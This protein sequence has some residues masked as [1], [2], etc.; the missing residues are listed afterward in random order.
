MAETARVLFI[1]SSAT[2]LPVCIQR[3]RVAFS[4]YSEC[5]RVCGRHCSF[6]PVNARI[7]C[8]RLASNY[9]SC[10]PEM[11]YL[12]GSAWTD[13]PTDQHLSTATLFP[14][15]MFSRARSRSPSNFR[16][17]ELCNTRVVTGPAEERCCV[18][19]VR[20][21]IHPWKSNGLLLLLQ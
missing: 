8:I 20:R 21:A 18:G 6:F 14:L 13:R 16:P 9:L 7:Y 10:A 19:T 15:D 12:T 11:L 4:T 1:R 17:S 2:V 3:L 5:L